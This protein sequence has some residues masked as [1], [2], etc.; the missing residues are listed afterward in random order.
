MVKLSCVTRSTQGLNVGAMVA[1]AF[2]QGNDVIDRKLLGLPA[3]C[4][5]ESLRRFDLPQFVRREMVGDSV[6]AS[7][8]SSLCRLRPFRMFLAKFLIIQC[9][10]TAKFFAWD[11]HG[12]P[13]ALPRTK[14]IA[15][16]LLIRAKLLV[17]NFAG[18][19]SNRICLMITFLRTKFIAFLRYLI[20]P[21]FSANRA[22]TDFRFI[23][24]PTFLRTIFCLSNCNP[25]WR[26]MECLPAMKAYSFHVQSIPHSHQLVNFFEA[27]R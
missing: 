23:T 18:I 10:V 9:T 4:A 15:L 5:L 20:S 21:C 13:I 3:H 19:F 2:R 27:Q 12:L 26:R 14:S 8:R 22:S 16:R 25:R 7:A 6:L 17:T 1:P 11:T 24:T